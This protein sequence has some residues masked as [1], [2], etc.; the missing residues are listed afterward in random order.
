MLPEEPPASWL[1][2]TS[3]AF[4]ALFKAPQ[5]GWRYA[6]WTVFGAICLSCVGLLVIALLQSRG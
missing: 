2:K 6:F 1:T 5:G 4:E 3:L